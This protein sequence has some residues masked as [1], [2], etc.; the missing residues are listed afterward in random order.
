MA[1]IVGYCTLSEL[2]NFA[3]TRPYSRPL[4]H[5]D[6]WPCRVV[7]SPLS[8]FYVKVEFKIAQPQLIFRY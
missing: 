1:S 5:M 4:V 2:G 7:K 3:F 6:L 8:P